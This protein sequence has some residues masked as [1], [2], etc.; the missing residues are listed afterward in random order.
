[1]LYGSQV[2]T[3][4]AVPLPVMSQKDGHAPKR[5]KPQQLKIT[6]AT[7]IQQVNGTE[8]ERMKITEI[9]QEQHTGCCQW[10]TPSNNG[11]FHKSIDY[12]S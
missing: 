12:R 6:Q 1:M 11:C 7:E 4:Q 2:R 10:V 5:Q 3:S 9:H 8:I